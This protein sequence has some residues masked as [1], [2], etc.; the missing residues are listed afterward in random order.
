MSK[1]KIPFWKKFL[2]GAVI[3]VLI[4]LGAVAAGVFGS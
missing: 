4:V 2:V 1:H 3:I